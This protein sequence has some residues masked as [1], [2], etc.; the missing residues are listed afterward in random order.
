MSFR[1]DL[2]HIILFAR[3]EF[4]AY[5][6]IQRLF[7]NTENLAA[8]PNR[9]QHAAQLQK[10][11]EKVC[12]TVFSDDWRFYFRQARGYNKFICLGN[13]VFYRQNLQIIHC[14]L[15]PRQKGL[16]QDLMGTQMEHLF[17][18]VFFKTL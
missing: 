6:P 17:L 7:N 5:R 3:P 10:E 14:I 11:I 4:Q 16:H 15:R 12:N 8:R 1:K 2:K 13:T 9:N 18:A